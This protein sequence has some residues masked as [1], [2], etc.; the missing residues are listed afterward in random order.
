MVQAYLILS[1]Y[2]RTVSKRERL[3]SYIYMTGGRAAGEHCNSHSVQPAYTAYHVHDQE[4]HL[5]E[6]SRKMAMICFIV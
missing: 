1:A 4:R 5:K 3:E 6:G 2:L